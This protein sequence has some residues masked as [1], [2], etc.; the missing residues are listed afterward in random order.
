VPTIRVDG[1]RIRD[2]EKKRQLVK[3]LT[4]TAVDI[5]GIE[6]IVVII[7]ENAPENVGVNGDLIT[8]LH[9]Q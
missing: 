9:D 5:Y 7:R 2:I 3:R 1:P 6:H 4:D 8:D